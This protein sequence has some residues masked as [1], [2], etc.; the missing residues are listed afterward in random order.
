[1]ESHPTPSFSDPKMEKS[2]KGL[3]LCRVLILTLLLGIAYLFQI[4]EKKYFFIPM[5]PPFYYFISLFYLTTAIYAFLLK[6]LKDLGTFALVQLFLDHLFIAGLILFTGG[7]ESYFPIAY[8]FTILGSSILFFKK[9]AFYSASFATLLYGL[10][11]LLQHYGWIRLP[12][13]T[14]PPEA[15]QVFY[16]LITYLAAFYII[17]FLSSL[18]AEELKKKKRELIQKQV[19]YEQLEAF[20]RNIVQ[21]LDSGLLTIDLEG[22]INF[23]NRTAEKILNRKA[24]ALKSRPIG[25]LFPE[26]A[27]VLRNFKPSSNPLLDYQRYET[28]LDEPDGRRTHL[29]FSISPLT[30]PEGAV[31][32]HILIFQDITR[33]KEMEE[34]MKRC[35]RMAAI[36]ALAAGMAHE[37]R[38]PLASLSGAIQMLKSELELDAPKEYLMDITLRET[39][40]LNA[41]IN[42]FLLFAHP[43]QLQ[44]SPWRIAPIL[45]ETI[46]LFRHSPYFHPGIQLTRANGEGEEI[47]AM[48]DPGQI[49]Q[50]FWNL[51]INAAQAIP[52]QGTIRIGIE[53]LCGAPRVGYAFPVDRA[54]EWVKITIADTGVGISPQEKE[55][56]F[57]PFYTTKEGGTGLGLSIVHKIIEN[58]Q[59]IIRVESEP[60]RGTAVIL[61]LPANVEGTPSLP[62][63]ERREC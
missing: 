51:L 15:S 4:Y 36:G 33:F 41:L 13:Q 31:I 21:S 26:I 59:G 38:N 23:L 7:N 1:M 25:E 24:E 10:T 27:K 18:V 45:D 43:P 50:V 49:R 55:K 63:G 47:E 14:A 28:L 5:T 16:P 11:L 2:I 44:P 48:I 35:D 29:G 56:I 53:K 30:D 6:R 52:E 19:D 61:Y 40:R 12:H 58:H 37:I 32:G 46:E 39:E 42:D 34:Q 17:A 54:D 57:D 8:F 60:G 3:M 9:G 62:P 20:N 22:R